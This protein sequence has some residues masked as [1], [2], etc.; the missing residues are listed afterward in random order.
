MI[1]TLIVGDD[2]ELEVEDPEPLGAGSSGSVY[3]VNV[4]A[5]GTWLIGKDSKPWKKQWPSSGID[6]ASSSLNSQFFA[7]KVIFPEKAPQLPSWVN[8]TPLPQEIKVVER[9][10]ECEGWPHENLIKI[11]RHCEIQSGFHG[12]DM[13]LCDFDMHQYIESPRLSVAHEKAMRGKRSPYEIIQVVRQ[14]SGG[15]EFIH[16]NKWVHRDIKP[17]NSISISEVV[18]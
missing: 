8:E 17:L 1:P 13:E 11:F 14:V 6:F 10:R 15:L 9:L 18:I 7:R 16:R 5:W 2:P 3:K 4:S 12:I